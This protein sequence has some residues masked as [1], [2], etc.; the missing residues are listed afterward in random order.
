MAVYFI[1]DESTGF[2]KIG[3]SDKPNKRLKSLQTS[4]ANKLTLVHAVEGDKALESALHTRFATHRVRGEW[5]S[6]PNLDEVIASANLFTEVQRGTQSAKS[7][8]E[9]IKNPLNWDLNDLVKSYENQIQRW[10]KLCEEMEEKKKEAQALLDEARSELQE[11]RKQRRED[12]FYFTEQMDMLRHPRDELENKT[13]IAH[14]LAYAL[15]I[16]IENLKNGSS[17]EGKL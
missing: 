10:K 2:V 8:K 7:A 15:K 11:E 17:F 16:H 13:P 3:Y 4:S 1:K 6:L 9:A 12:R 5:F 14:L